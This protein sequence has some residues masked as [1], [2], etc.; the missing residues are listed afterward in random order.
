MLISRAYGAG[1]GFPHQIIG[2]PIIA[3]PNSC[4]T[5]TYLVCGVFSTQAEATH[6]AQFLRTRFARFLVFLRKNTQDTN[7]DKFAF[8]PQLPMATAWCDATLYQRYGFTPQE[9]AFIERMIKEMP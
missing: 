8:V 2:E 3:E 7:K 5:E 4:C 9:V 1:E 6:F